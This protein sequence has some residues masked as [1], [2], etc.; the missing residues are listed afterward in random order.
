[1]AEKEFWLHPNQIKRLATGYGGCFATDLITVEGH[2][3]GFMYRQEPENQ[4]DSG[5]R[6]LSGKESQQYLDDQD[7]LAIYDVNTIVNYDSEIIPFLDAPVGSAFER[8]LKSDKFVE[9]GFDFLED[10]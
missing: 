1:M 2:K 6:F 5:W 8:D 4:Y 3:V 9:V 7:N 10:A